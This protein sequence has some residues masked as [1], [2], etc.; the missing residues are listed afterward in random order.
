MSTP[1]YTARLTVTLADTAWHRY[2]PAEFASMGS[3][4]PMAR[5]QRIVSVWPE[6][7]A[8]QNCSVCYG[9][10]VG[11]ADGGTRGLIIIPDLAITHARDRIAGC[12]LTLKNQTITFENT[13]D[14]SSGTTI[15]VSGKS[16]A[17]VAAE[18]VALLTIA[19]TSIADLEVAEGSEPG[20]I[21]LQSDAGATDAATWTASASG[22]GLTLYADGLASAS[23]SVLDATASSWASKVMA[24]EQVYAISL[25]AN[26][27]GSVV[28]LQMEVETVA[29]PRSF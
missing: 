15:D 9:D 4:S 22:K 7:V 29:T 19:A 12:T 26:S 3:L 6:S 14:G 5:G 16:R 18:V 24:D 17:T 10:R 2:S 28:T 23:A 8:T 13:G 20:A 11:D 21:V 25:R 1:T 27:A